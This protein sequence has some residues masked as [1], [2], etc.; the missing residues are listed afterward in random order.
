MGRRHDTAGDEARLVQ[1]SWRVLDGTAVAAWNALAARASEP[2]PFFE[3]W[4]LLPSLRALDPAGR[5]RLLIMARGDEWLG[6]MPVTDE[7][8][9]YGYPAPHLRNWTHANC[10]VGAPLVAAGEETAFWR[11]LLEWADRAGGASLFLHMAHLPLSG[12]LDV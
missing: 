5:V 10:F 12:G 8:S 6:L 4:Y 7:T 3:S 2:N 11:G 9:Y 1:T